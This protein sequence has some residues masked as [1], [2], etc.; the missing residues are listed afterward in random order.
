MT[1][2]SLV[3]YMNDANDVLSM[4]VVKLVGKSIKD[5]EGYVSSP[6][7][8]GP[9]LVLHRLVFEDG[10]YMFFEGE[11]DLVS[12]STFSKGAHFLVDFEDLWD[13]EED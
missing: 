4:S 13:E 6:Y 8:D 9:F 12:L 10:T 5:I 2:L 7:G 3:P 1:R 11:H